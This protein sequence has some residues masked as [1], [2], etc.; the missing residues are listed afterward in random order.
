MNTRM[1]KMSGKMLMALSE[2]EQ[3]CL[4]DLWELDLRRMGGELLRFCNFQNEKNQA[5]VWKGQT[6]TTYPIHAEGFE[7]SGNGTAN[8]P[9]LTVS[10]VMGLV[11][12]LA[13]KHNQLVGAIVTRRQT[14]AQFLD[15]ANFQAAQN[16][17]ADP[18]QEIV[19]KFT[20]EQL[21]N[22]NAETATFTLATPSEAD[23]AIVPARMMFA[24]VCVW[25]YRGAECGYGGRPVADRFGNP[26][27][28]P[29]QDA[30]GQRLL[31]CQ[32]RFGKN[33]VLPFGGFPS[34]DKVS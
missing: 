10:N 26:T 19:S 21:S 15:A 16:P 13:E 32:A 6:Y 11:T 29:A 12:G 20:I 30:C 24:S 33:A 3:D 31:D 1:Q 28:D 23:G 9:K 17:K 2:L 14:Y 27:S 22:L 5:I 34:C 18:T 8:R 25:Q 7:L 4:I